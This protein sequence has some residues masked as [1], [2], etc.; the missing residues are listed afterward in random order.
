[1]ADFQL[2]G[3]ASARLRTV[4]RV[5]V[6]IALVFAIYQSGIWRVAKTK[7]RATA[8]LGRSEQASGG[9]G[10]PALYQYCRSANDEDFWMLAAWCG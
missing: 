3:S 2:A 8:V 6:P 7:R 9:R 1:M 5:L 4:L 10:A